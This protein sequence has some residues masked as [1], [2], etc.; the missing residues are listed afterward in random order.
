MSLS[1]P[2]S[3]CLSAR[4]SAVLSRLYLIDY[5]SNRFQ[6]LYGDFTLHEDVQRRSFD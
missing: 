1:V 5:S 3:L 4:L 6:I 2:L